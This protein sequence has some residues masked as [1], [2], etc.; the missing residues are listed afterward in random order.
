MPLIQDLKGTLLPAKPPNNQVGSASCKQIGS[1]TL[2]SA[3]QD[4]AVLN[5]SGGAASAMHFKIECMR[6][7]EFRNSCA[8]KSAEELWGWEQRLRGGK[9]WQKGR[10]R[11]NAELGRKEESSP[12][13]MWLMR[14]FFRA[15][16]LMSESLSLKSLSPLPLSL[17]LNFSASRPEMVLKE[18]PF[19]TATGG[20]GSFPKPGEAR[21]GCSREWGSRGEG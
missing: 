12:L 13:C 2:A 6:P 16:P 14:S 18:C 21:K 8:E 10:E 20:A 11:R 3:D 17:P 7:A 9:K 4:G 5:S 1:I 15:S 19:Q